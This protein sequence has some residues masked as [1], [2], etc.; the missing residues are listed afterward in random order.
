MMFH[1]HYDT[2]D[3]PKLPPPPPPPAGAPPGP[4]PPTGNALLSSSKLCRNQ[5]FRFKNRLFGFQYHMEMDEAGLEAM[6]STGQEDIARV[7]GPDGQ[8]QIQQDTVRYYRHYRRMGDRIV[9]NF[10]QYLKLY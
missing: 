5:A 2:F 6:V 9:Q 8:R 4:P 10:I 1:W 7:L 3:L